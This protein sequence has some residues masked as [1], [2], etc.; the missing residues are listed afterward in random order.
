MPSHKW[1]FGVDDKIAI[2]IYTIITVGFT[3]QFV[4]P[5]FSSPDH[6]D[7]SIR[8]RRCRAISTLE[9]THRDQEHFHI[10]DLRSTNPSPSLSKSL[11]RH[12]CVVFLPVIDA[13]GLQHRS[14]IFVVIG[15]IRQLLKVLFSVIALSQFG[16]WNQYPSA[17]LSSSC[18]I[19]FHPNRF[20]IAQSGS[21]L[22]HRHR[23]QAIITVGR[24]I[25]FIR[26]FPSSQRGHLH[27]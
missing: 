25:G 24:N 22:C 16:S 2:V 13:V 6:Q 3:T 1:I 18:C 23:C 27:R 5:P 4:N 11:Q 9:R 21:T 15:A 7:R 19:G 17:S 26:S 20:F 14:S 10:L 12:V 8:L